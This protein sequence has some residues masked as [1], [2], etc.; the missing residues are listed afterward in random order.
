MLAQNQNGPI[1][2]EQSMQMIEEQGAS[3]DA[4][5]QGLIL[6]VSDRA[7]G[8]Q[9]TVAQPSSIWSRIQ[10]LFTDHRSAAIEFETEARYQIALQACAGKP[11]G[12]DRGMV[13]N[14]AEHLFSDDSNI[15]YMH[16]WLPQK[17]AGYEKSLIT[18]IGQSL[19]K[20]L[21]SVESD[22]DGIYLAAFHAF[23]GNEPTKEHW[24]HALAQTTTPKQRAF[25][26]ERMEEWEGILRTHLLKSNASMYTML[27]DPLKKIY[28]ID[29]KTDSIDGL[30]SQFATYLRTQKGEVRL[31]PA[32]TDT[33][34]GFNIKLKKNSNKYLNT[35]GPIS[36]GKDLIITNP[37]HGD[38]GTYKPSEFDI[39]FES[40]FEP[41]FVKAY[42]SIEKSSADIIEKEMKNCGL[43]NLMSIYHPQI[44]DEIAF[45]AENRKL[46]FE[47]FE[48]LQ[49]RCNL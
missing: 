34:N 38:Q 3:R 13:K 29:L 9:T 2:L 36:A 40:G 46:L 37:A 17:V 39:V 10:T 44:D 45:M 35:S 26:N 1:T 41:N 19:T 4:I 47:R 33:L 12:I 48:D 30:R 27:F 28:G 6:Y 49:N 15:D 42:G 43:Y 24:E 11:F 23:K 18:N 31:N 16:L 5:A 21:Q 32:L 8:V 22:I 7:N 25:L 20:K 14:Y